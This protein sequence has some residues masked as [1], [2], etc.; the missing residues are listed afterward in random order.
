MKLTIINN[1]DPKTWVFD[2]DAEF[3]HWVNSVIRVENEDFDM[4]ITCK[5]EAIEYINNYCGNLEIAS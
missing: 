3:V 4:S 2:N 5:G 1:V